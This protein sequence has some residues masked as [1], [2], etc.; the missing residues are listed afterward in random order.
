MNA[1]VRLVPVIGLEVN[2]HRAIG[3]HAQAEDQ[4]LEIGTV[5]L[6]VA[7]LE[8]DG[9]GMLSVI[10]AAE[11]DAGGVVV[12]LVH[13]E[14]EAAHDREDDARLQGGTVGGE[15]AIERPSPTLPRASNGAS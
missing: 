15:Q 12:D 8:L 14:I 13:L 7:A 5:L 10:G 9:F 1:I 4:L 2:G 11:H 3:R 6:A